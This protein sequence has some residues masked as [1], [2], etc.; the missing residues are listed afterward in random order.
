MNYSL[1]NTQINYE[2]IRRIAKA[3]GD[4]NE[5]VI[6]VGGA[7]V[8]LYINDPAADDIRPTKDL[9]ISLS[10]A[11]LTELE[12]VRVK[13]SSRGFIQSA[14]DDIVCRFRYQDIKVDVMNTKAI[15]WAPANPWFEPGFRSRERRTVDDEQIWILS[16]PYFLASKF[17]AFN[18]RGLKDPR[19]SHDFED[20]VYILD[21]RTDI[22]EQLKDLP[23]DV[24]P[25]LLEQF[26]SIIKDN[27]KLEAVRSHI[28]FQGRG[29][30][31][32]RILECI[33]EFTQSN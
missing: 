32:D 14:E 25:Y 10:L 11:S 22:S 21:N 1:K 33:K 30:R 18:N 6:Y 23:A 31:Y 12:N 2:I 28:P 17:E 16:L 3:L 5:Q 29:E 7:V 24:K 4:L 15:G 27:L 8:S 26:K 13:L 19:A 20:I 9:D